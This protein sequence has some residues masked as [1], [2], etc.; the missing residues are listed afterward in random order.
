MSFDALKYM[1]LMNI[2][3][4]F[5]RTGW[6]NLLNCSEV[7]GITG[8][9]GSAFPFSEA[10]KWEVNRYIVLHWNFDI[11]NLKEVLGITDHIFCPSDGK[12]YEKE[13]RYS[14]TSLWWTDFDSPL[15]IHYNLSRFRCKNNNINF[16]S[17]Q[18]FCL[19]GIK[20]TWLPFLIGFNPFNPM[21]KIQILICC[22]WMF[23]IQLVGRIC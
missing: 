13:P 1:S 15:A 11:T 7:F 9:Y 18:Y 14:K 3:C 5:Y 12:I 6:R 20:N 16:F 8:L 22:P 2:F 19:Q 10:Y 23:S 17:G 4:L 21:M